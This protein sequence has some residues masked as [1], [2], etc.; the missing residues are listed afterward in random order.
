MMTAALLGGVAMLCFW[1][2]P[3]PTAL[4]AAAILG[5]AASE[6][7]AT[8]QKKNLRTA[9]LVVIVGAAGMPLAT[10]SK[11]TY[12]FIV[13]VGLVLVTTMLWFLFEAGPGRPLIGAAMTLLAFGWVGGLGGFAGLLLHAD[14]GVA[15]LLAALLPTI[16]YDVFGFFIGQQWGKSPIAPRI[17][18]NKT[19]EGTSG[20][21]L[22]SVVIGATLLARIEPFEGNERWAVLIGLAVGLAAVIG[23]LCES[24]IKRDLAIKDFSGTLPGHGGILDRFDG[25]LFALPVVYFLMIHFL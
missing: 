15:W 20:G 5:A 24:M 16:A 10:W 9:N 2:G 13:V 3:G 22:A 1:A 25:L 12:G 11:G 8:L 4:L 21:V 6:L 7:V 17:S 14:N 19:I 23:D 18:P